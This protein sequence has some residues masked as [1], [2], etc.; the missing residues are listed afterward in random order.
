MARTPLVAGNWKMHCTVAES[1]VLASRIRQNL[2]SITSVEVAVCP[3]YTSL[4]PVA[5]ILSD[6]SI[7]VGAQ[8]VFYE[9]AGAYTGEV[10]PLMLAELCHY[11]IVGHSERRSMFGDSD[12]VVARKVVALRAHGIV[13]ILCIGEDLKQNEAGQTATVVERQLR[14]VFKR[15]R[16]SPDMLVAYEP[17]WAIGTGRAAEPDTVNETAKFIRL[18]LA[19]MSDKST[20]NSVRIL[21][22]GSVSP[23]NA[24]EYVN[25]SDIDGYL[26]GGAS[27]KS[28]DFCDI[29]FTTAARQ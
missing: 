29:V 19:D 22:G 9:D 20:A 4:K 18:L 11:C 25:R 6:S 26:V 23:Q 8:D 21:Y 5:D 12:D 27:L 2:G 1:L 28:Q 14:A 24:A 7:R 10:S 13:P 17:I 3:P 16:P 15:Q